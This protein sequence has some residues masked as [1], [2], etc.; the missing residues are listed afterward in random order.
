M[1]MPGVGDK[2]DDDERK[3]NAAQ[4]LEINFIRTEQKHRLQVEA[5]RKLKEQ[6]NVQ[7]KEKSRK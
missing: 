6:E 1:T 5:E 7:K 4:N 2:D 3:F